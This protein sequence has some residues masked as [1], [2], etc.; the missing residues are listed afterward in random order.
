MTQEL[1]TAI[2]RLQALPESDQARVAAQINEYL[3]RLERLREMVHD[4]LE[5]GPATPLD[6]DAIIRQ[7]EARLT[8]LQQQDVS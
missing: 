3:T 5:S 7:G 4:G 1:E 8:A 2:A 6:M